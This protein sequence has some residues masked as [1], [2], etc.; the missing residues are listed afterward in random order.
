MVGRSIPPGAPLDIH[1]RVHKL[2][3]NQAAKLTGR[4]LEDIFFHVGRNREKGIA[5]VERFSNPDSV[6][7]QGNKLFIPKGHEVMLK[8]GKKNKKTLG[9][10]VV[11]T[12][13]ELLAM[14]PFEQGVLSENAEDLLGTK[15]FKK[16]YPN[17]EPPHGKKL[18]EQGHLGNDPKAAEL[19]GKGYSYD[20][21]MRLKDPQNRFIHG[22]DDCQGEFQ[23]VHTA[24]GK[25]EYIEL[26]Y[27]EERWKHM[28]NQNISLGKQQTQHSANDIY[29]GKQ[30]EVIDGKKRWMSL[31]EPGRAESF[32][33]VDEDGT[34]YHVEDTA[35]LQDVYKA[36]GWP[37]R[38]PHYSPPP[39]PPASKPQ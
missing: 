35:A 31:R 8:T 14:R 26:G 13:E 4:N 38:Y 10:V 33:I 28:R 3:T 34:L 22:D 17:L 6:R 37:W 2:D 9:L 5:S 20:R 29:L 21:E 18:R 30:P 25:K 24:E 39:R 16:L 23:A 19:P 7:F 32:L 1:P 36:R 15:E 11:P 12:E 27:E